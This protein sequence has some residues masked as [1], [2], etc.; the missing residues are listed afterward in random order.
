MWTKIRGGGAHS[1]NQ[2]TAAVCVLERQ[3]T[4][5][6]EEPWLTA[7]SLQWDGEEESMYERYTHGVNIH[8]RFPCS[9]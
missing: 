2:G 5:L 8:V 4:A 7:V 1:P 9:F 3:Q 6:P